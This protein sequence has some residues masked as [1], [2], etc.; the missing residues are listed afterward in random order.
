MVSPGSWQYEQAAIR[1]GR[2][3][4]VMGRGRGQRDQKRNKESQK[5]RGATANPGSQEFR[6]EDRNDPLHGKRVPMPYD[7]LLEEADG[8]NVE[9]TR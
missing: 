5:L 1:F 6:E 8:S 3:A 4:G 7:N 2:Q 9:I